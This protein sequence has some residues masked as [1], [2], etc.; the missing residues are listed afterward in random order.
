M[1]PF[2][3][4]KNEI[5]SFGRSCAP[6]QTEASVTATAVTSW[7]SVS[8]DIKTIKHSL[9]NYFYLSV[10]NSRSAG[11]FDD[12]SLIN[13]KLLGFTLSIGINYNYEINSC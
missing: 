5:L 4:L 8:R 3:S 10:Q 6:V 12:L 13:N 2:Y 1:K 11:L 7:A 9:N